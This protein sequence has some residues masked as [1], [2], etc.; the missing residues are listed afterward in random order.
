MIEDDRS[1]PM[2][3]PT[4]R[5]S[6]QSVT[7]LRAST[8]VIENGS[9]LT[10]NS[11]DLKNRER[12]KSTRRGPTGQ[13]KNRNSVVLIVSGPIRDLEIPDMKNIRIEEISNSY[14]NSHQI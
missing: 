14:G 9:D 5:S 12:C 11:A 10:E 7:E 4:A 3:N 2:L 13:L 8:R 6:D 1:R